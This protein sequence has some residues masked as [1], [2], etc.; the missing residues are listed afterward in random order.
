[1]SHKHFFSFIQKK[2]RRPITEV[3]NHT[4]VR[5]RA[6]QQQQQQQHHHHLQWHNSHKHIQTEFYFFLYF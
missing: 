6:W 3:R 1:M 5:A 2:N 4:I